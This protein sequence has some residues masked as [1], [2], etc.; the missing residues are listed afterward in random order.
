M[1]QNVGG[2][3]RILRI[4]VGLVLVILAATGVLG[5]WAWLGV[6][7]LATGLVGICMPYK[8]FGFSTCAIKT[9]PNSVTE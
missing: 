7:L 9:D 8:L 4:A 3:D 5:P 2:I 6:I 1:T